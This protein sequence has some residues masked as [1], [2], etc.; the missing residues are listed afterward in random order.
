[1]ARYTYHRLFRKKQEQGVTIEEMAIEMEIPRST[2][3]KMLAAKSPREF[4]LK[5]STLKKFYDY[6]RCKEMKELIRF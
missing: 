5:A 6:F 1:M 4:N 3:Y 2:I